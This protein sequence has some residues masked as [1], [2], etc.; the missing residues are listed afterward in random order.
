MEI[1]KCHRFP[2]AEGV[3]RLRRHEGSRGLRPQSNKDTRQS[4]CPASMHAK[5]EKS[6]PMHVPILYFVRVRA[7]KP[8]W[9]ICCSTFSSRYRLGPGNVALH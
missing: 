7:A 8:Q 1:R 6:L 9:Q 3:V 4:G 5:N 2:E